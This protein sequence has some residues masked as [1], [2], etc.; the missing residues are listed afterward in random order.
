MPSQ[1]TQMDREN[2]LAC[3]EING[4]ITATSAQTGVPQ[5][6][7]RYWRQKLQEEQK[8]QQNLARLPEKSSDCRQSGN[9]I[10]SQ[11][12]E[13]PLELPQQLQMLRDQM[14]RHTFTLSQSLSVDDERINERAIALTRLIDRVL[15]LE[16]AIQQ[17]GI[18]KKDQVYRIEYVY[19]DETIHDIPIW[20][21]P[22]Y[23]TEEDEEFEREL[24]RRQES[25]PPEFRYINGL[26]PDPPSASGIQ[27]N[28]EL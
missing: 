3:L 13:E 12:A 8:W 10:E 25:G 9:K 22:D 4:S 21:N 5:R 19:P 24:R 16:T 26:K 18:Y 20:N 7:L 28:D 27:Y 23:Y 14:M 6:T 17:S 15:K 1:Y 2:A 11:E